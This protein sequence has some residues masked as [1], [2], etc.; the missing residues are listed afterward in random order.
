MDCS[1]PIQTS[2]NAYLVALKVSFCFLPSVPVTNILMKNSGKAQVRL[3]KIQENRVATVLRLKI[4]GS[5]G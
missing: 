5:R 1:K 3:G 2:K 4:M